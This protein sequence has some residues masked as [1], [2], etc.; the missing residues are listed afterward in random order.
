MLRRVV[1]SLCIVAVAGAVTLIVEP[2]I[3]CLM[4]GRATVE[5]RI[6]E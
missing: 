6:Q 2:R 3:I 1:I 5:D 4:R